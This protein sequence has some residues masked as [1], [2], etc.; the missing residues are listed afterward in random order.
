VA[1]LRQQH[2]FGRQDSEANHGAATRAFL[3]EAQMSNAYRL[4]VD[5]AALDAAT[6]AHRRFRKM[7]W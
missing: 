7:P 4:V 5:E 3:P 2:A 6:A 1:V